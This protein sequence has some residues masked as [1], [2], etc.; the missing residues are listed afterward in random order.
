M[1]FILALLMVPIYLLY[2][3]ITQNHGVFNGQVTATCIG[4]LLI[5]TLAFSAALSLFT[6]AKRH[7]ILGA[8]AAYVHDCVLIQALLIC[9]QVLCCFG[10]IFGQCEVRVRRPDFES[11]HLSKQKSTGELYVDIASNISRLFGIANTY[12]GI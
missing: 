10:R 4:I 7:E 2:H 8:A 11:K 6:R 12:V 3:L 9:F 5:S 1:V